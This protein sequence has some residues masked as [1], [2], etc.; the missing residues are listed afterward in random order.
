[1]LGQL[2]LASINGDCVCGCGQGRSPVARGS[3]RGVSLKRHGERERGGAPSLRCLDRRENHERRVHAV[4]GSSGTLV[5]QDPGLSVRRV[6][7]LLERDAVWGRG[8]CEKSIRQWEGGEVRCRWRVQLE[9][10]AALTRLQEEWGWCQKHLRSVSLLE[11]F[12]SGGNVA[13]VRFKFNN[14]LAAAYC[15]VWS[16]FPAAVL[17][18]AIITP[19]LFLKTKKN[20]GNCFYLFIYF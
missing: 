10:P 18:H 8:L 4:I 16:A 19:N 5:T 14:Q 2:Q 13:A 6:W 11:G 20:Y 1:M 9:T 3:S 17:Q 12:V 7:S 15:S